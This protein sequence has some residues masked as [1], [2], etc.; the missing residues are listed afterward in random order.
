MRVTTLYAGM[1]LAELKKQKIAILGGGIGAMSAALELTSAPDWQDRYEITVYQMGWRLGGKGAS[2]RDRNY[3]NRIYEHG[4]HLWMGFYENAFRQMETAYAEWNAKGYEPKPLWKKYTDAFSPLNYVIAMEQLAGSW[5]PWLLQFPESSFQ[6]GQD[7]PGLDR[8]LD[9]WD[10]TL[11]AVGMMFVAFLG[12]KW[13][14]GLRG[15]L[16]KLFGGVALW[17]LEHL[18]PNPIVRWLVR[19][20]QGHTRG[21]WLLPIAHLYGHVEHRSGQKARPGHQRIVVEMLERFAIWFETE[22]KG[23]EERKDIAR[24][25]DVMLDTGLALVR[26]VV[27]DDVVR[28]GY[29]CL[30]GEDFMAWLGRHG[31]RQPENPVTRFFYDACFAYRK[32][33]DGYQPDVPSPDRMGLNMAAGA[34]LYGLLRLV[35]TYKGGIMNTMGAGM[36]DTIFSPFYVVLKNRGVRFQFFHRVRALELS[37]DRKDVGAIHIAVQAIAQNGHYDPIFVVNGVP[38]WPSE[39]FYEQLKD[40]EGLKGQDLE[41]YWNAHAPAKEITL[42]RGQDFDTVIFGISVGAIP[43]LCGELIASN[44]QWQAMV[45]RVETV[46]T[47]AMQIWLKRTQKQMGWDREPPILTGFVEPHDTWCAMDHLIERESWPP[48]AGLRQIAYFCNA[49]QECGA[50]KCSPECLPARPIPGCPVAHALSNPGFPREQRELVRRA[51][52]EFMNRDLRH[53]WPLSQDPE[54]PGQFDWNALACLAGAVA[55]EPKG[56]SAFNQQ[57]WRANYEPT[58]RYVQSIAGSTRYRLNP[59]DSG[60]RNLFLAGD[61]TYT[62]INIGCVESACISGKMAAWGISGSPNFIYGPMGYPEPIDRIRYRESS[63]DTSAAGASG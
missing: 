61:W 53:L 37:D 31:C 12:A 42:R 41:S 20:L 46:K 33:R 21:P 22:S 45:E 15:W 38:A 63:R 26:G 29:D 24:R 49:M 8:P 11:Q 56:E 51:S 28:R 16:L 59:A 39:P 6:P 60:F 32:G 50:A 4:L 3:A 14:T 10:L 7:I 23:R 43:L 30:D 57:Y 9:L 44:P 36:G 1:P 52:I 62:P 34:V 5:N 17:I 13:E 27:D 48:S 40:P 55:Q 54:N 35:G 18:G 58:E 47:Q 19:W 25:L 2:G